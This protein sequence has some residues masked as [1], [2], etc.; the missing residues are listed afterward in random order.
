MSVIEDCILCN[1]PVTVQIN[2]TERK[3]NSIIDE[4]SKTHHSVI[5]LLSIRHVERITPEVKA[6]NNSLMKKTRRKEAYKELH[7]RRNSEMRKMLSWLSK[8]LFDVWWWSWRWKRKDESVYE[9]RS[10]STCGDKNKDRGE[11]WSRPDPLSWTENQQ[12]YLCRYVNDILTSSLQPYNR[13]LFAK[14]RRKIDTK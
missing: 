11:L 4:E 10:P 2:V 12:P 7:L 1:E 6:F 13:C 5:I 3:L 14:K 9:R 8:M